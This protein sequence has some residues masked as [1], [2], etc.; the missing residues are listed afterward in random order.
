MEQAYRLSAE[1]LLYAV[2]K[3]HRSGIYG[4]PNGMPKMSDKSFPAFV[5]D[6]EL[7]LM[8]AGCGTLNFDGEFVLNESFAALLGGC[9]DCRDVV[10]VSL[11][12]NGVWHKLTLYLAAGAV[13]E[14]EEDFTCTL[15]AAARPAEVLEAALDLPENP[16][17]PLREALVDTDLLE[18]RDL[19]GVVAA[20]CGEGEANMIMAA[21]DGAGRY[22]HIS[23]VENRAQT[24]EML[25][26][27]G[28]E[29][30]LSADVEYS[31]TQE[32]LRL[33]PLTRAETLERMRVLAAEPAEQEEAP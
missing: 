25:L 6:A 23:R 13:L 26:F 33:T 27:Y 3:L 2:L 20:G 28:A 12:R 7:E 32:L 9:A 15:R 21:L 10:G 24:A 29:G 30:V 16:D 18:K 8:D 4:L 1:A 31:E 11:R 17:Q 22:A 5:Q 14:R 19:K